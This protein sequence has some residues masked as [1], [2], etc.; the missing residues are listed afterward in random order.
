MVAPLLGIALDRY[1]RPSSRSATASR[2]SAGTSLD[3]APAD[4]V[5]G[6]AEEPN[7]L[8]VLTVTQDRAAPAAGVGGARA[9]PPD[10]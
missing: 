8:V 5:W 9:L 4:A 10:A 2:S 1:D 3:D 7:V 6:D